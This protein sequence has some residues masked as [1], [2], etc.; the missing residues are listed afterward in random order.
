MVKSIESM[1]IKALRDLKSF[2]RTNRRIRGKRPVELRVHPRIAQRV[3]NED[4]SRLD[5]LR[6]TLRRNIAVVSDDN[7]HIEEVKIVPPR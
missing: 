6:K 1:V 5:H 7:L 2:F 4:A 3:V